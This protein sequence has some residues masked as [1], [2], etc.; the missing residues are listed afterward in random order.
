MTETPHTR[1]QVSMTETPC[2][3]SIDDAVAA[4]QPDAVAEVERAKSMWP[5]D[6]GTDDWQRAFELRLMDESK[7]KTKRFTQKE[8]K[9]CATAVEKLKKR[10]MAQ[11]KALAKPRARKK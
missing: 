1:Q 4:G 7:E 9:R 8:A 10:R 6:D 3:A 5:G 11:I 2:T